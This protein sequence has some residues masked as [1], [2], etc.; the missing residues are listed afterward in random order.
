MT[1][2][3]HCDA[4]L[5][6]NGAGFEHFRRRCSSLDWRL[7][8]LVFGSLALLS[9]L[10]A[11]AFAVAGAWLIIPFAGLEIVALGVA[12]WWTLRR[13]DDFER[14][15]FDGDRILLD[16]KEQGLSRHFEFNRC[17][18]R[19]VTGHA[20]AVALRSH[21]REVAIGR[22]CGEESRQELAREVRSRLGGH[23]I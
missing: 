9:V 4:D 13:A 10:V 18:A 6:A 1:T 19:L 14:L 20:G 21:G 5:T 3:P 17:W 2:K 23:R 15:T 8:H 16:V 22:F 7:L 12:A 11:G